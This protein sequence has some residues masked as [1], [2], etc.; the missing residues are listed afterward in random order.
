MFAVE[1]EPVALVVIRASIVAPDVVVIDR[2][3]EKELPDVIQGLGVGIG[4]PETAQP[5]RTLGEGDV[6][7]VVVGIGQRRVAAVVG[8]G[9]VRAASVV[10][11][12][13]GAGRSILV[14]RRNQV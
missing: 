5:R 8:I 7:A 2:L 1:D 3:A 12:R 11:A 4:N 14:L 6:Q 13:R 9:R 10:C